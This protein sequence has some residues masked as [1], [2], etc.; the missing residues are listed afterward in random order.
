MDLIIDLLNDKRDKKNLGLEWNVEIIE[1]K[2][3]F[4][5]RLPFVR[6]HQHIEK[7]LTLSIK[8]L[9]V[10]P[11][12]VCDK[13]K[14][15]TLIYEGHENVCV[16]EPIT[17]KVEKEKTP[18][19]LFIDQ[20]AIHD[21]SE[22]QK[23]E[24]QVYNI[25]FDVILKDHKDK[26][27]DSLHQNINVKFVALDVKP[28]VILDFGTNS[29]AYSSQL[30]MVKLGELITY[31]NEEFLY[32]PVVN[33]E[34][35]LRLFE[36]GVPKTDTLFF[37]NRKTRMEIQQK[38][39]R[40]AVKTL[41]ICM[42]FT[43]ISNPIR[44][45]C[46]YVIEVGIIQSMEYS[47][48]VK[49]PRIPVHAKISV[50]KDKQGTELKVVVSNPS[51]DKK[52]LVAS[53][54]CYQVGCV[55]F[56]PHSRMS[57]QIEV[58]IMNIATD[59]SNPNAGLIIRNFTLSENILNDVRV[60]DKDNN[61]LFS[62]INV[63]GA[64]YEDLKGG[65]GLEI[66]NGIDAKTTL[67][68]S[69]DPSCIADI[70]QC[71]NY[72]FQ[73]ES[74]LTFDYWE[75][76]DGVDLSQLEPKNF[77]L[78]IVWNL[79]LEPHPEWLCVDYGT[80][81]IVCKYDKKIIDLKEQKDKIF[82][83]DF[84]Q[85]RNDE[86][87]K[88]TKFLSS[89]IVL[90]SV[91]DYGIKYTS[92]CS[93]QK[94][95]DNLPYNTLAVCLSPTSSLIENEVKMQLPCLKIL[96]GNQYLPPKPDYL[97]FQ[98]LRKN[99]DGIVE[100]VV[101]SDT[102]DDEN[103]ILKIS[104]I[105]REA[106]SAL[107]RYFISPVTGDKSHLNKLVLTYPN[108]YTP[109]HLKVL[110]QIAMRTFPAIREGFLRF[111]SESDAVAAYYVDHWS[112][113]NPEGDIRQKETVLVFDMGAG[114][115]DVTLFDKFTN[116]EGKI[117][118]NIKGKLGTGKAGNYLD[119]VLA[120]IVSELTHTGS[121]EVV[122]TKQV[123]NVQILKER[124]E[125]K[126]AIKQ[127]LK[128]NLQ[129][130]NKMRY[131]GITIDTD[132]I[133]YHPKFIGFLSDVTSHIIDQLCQ[134]MDTEKLA[135]DTVIMSGR[136]CKLQLLRDELAN[137]VTARSTGGNHFVEFVDSVQADCDKTVVVEGAI[138]QASKFNT[139]TSQ[140]V[141]KSRRLYASYG[142]VYKELGGRIK[143]VELLNHNNIPYA[144]N[145]VIF[146]SE[147]VTAVGTSAAETLHLIQTYLSAAETE[148]CYN[149]GNFEFISEMEEF[150]TED[151]GKAD[152]LNM[153]LRLDCNNSISLFVNGKVSRGS[154][155]KGVDLASE[156]TRRSIWPV[157]I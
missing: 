71:P 128:P 55:S 151:F 119:F 41:P 102:Q 40:K 63:D 54:T 98:Y 8:N 68:I 125:L 65:A 150:N 116:D 6:S 83:T 90:H 30:G 50:Q 152:S 72:N 52:S 134:Y 59:S 4:F 35:D 31:I 79:H 70:L 104:S 19:Q 21:C 75:N 92:L 94:Q 100:R 49:V 135:I 67:A 26:L 142:V 97:T 155:P 85:F 9:R 3:G 117:E 66:K 69:F 141:I 130:G 24:T 88:G 29:I 76:K 144:D 105:F 124:L 51:T 126:Q 153:K 114:T 80:S 149:E 61:E 45:E 14:L 12:I 62:L 145:M 139:P 38:P 82:R 32:T 110:R 121:A 138:A 13:A 73:I 11:E 10:A 33:L 47:P 103:S 17:L 120:E 18:F 112:E 20:S 5:S 147:N 108:T 43:R 148:K 42:D 140:V 132:A 22:R 77:K 122:T 96:V 123:P 16:D 143:F 27:V 95:N 81:A 7:T 157:T 133:I 118:V 28:N 46:E 39:S 89:D 91:D 74:I 15:F 60:V 37:D 156:I 78:S 34:L 146:D 53:Q 57:S 56:V 86:F 129:P 87:E 127:E 137:S 113:F 107:F 64:D 44:P 111:V 36:D 23:R 1:P 48:E 131:K 115:L 109:A 93:E 84:T 106:Y 101:A 136:S 58:D 2:K 99:S 25:C 154:T